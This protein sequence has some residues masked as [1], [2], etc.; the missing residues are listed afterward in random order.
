M[1]DV[2]TPLRAGTG[3][4]GSAA[5]PDEVACLRA[6]VAALE[7]LL[8]AH[9]QAVAAQCRHLE[10]SLHEIQARTPETGPARGGWADRPQLL[11][12]I[13]NS[14]GEGVIGADVNG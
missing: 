12:S 10:Q 4:R 13:F 9:Q 1:P 2:A 6:Q 8:L 14:I 3:S 7:Q 11:Q 5:S